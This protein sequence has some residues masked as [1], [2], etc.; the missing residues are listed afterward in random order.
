MR[1]PRVAKRIDRS[2]NSDRGPSASP[3]SPPLRIARRRPRGRRQSG[4]SA[5]RRMVYPAARQMA[6]P[7]CPA[8]VGTP[9]TDQIPMRMSALA[10]TAA[11]QLP[12]TR[13]RVASASGG[14]PRLGPPL[15]RVVA[16][17]PLVRAL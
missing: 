12:P 3:A 13:T 17:E 8:L 4:S 5:A 14:E 1:V 9:T 2:V 11:P 7:S 6:I 10:A 15:E 16:L